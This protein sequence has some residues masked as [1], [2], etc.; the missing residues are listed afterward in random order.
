MAEA[1]KNPSLN[2]L[3]IHFG[4]W[5]ATLGIAPFLEQGKTILGHVRPW[6]FAGCS[7]FGAEYCHNRMIVRDVYI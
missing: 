2:D 1:L 7:K 4:K 3:R 6:L 5:S